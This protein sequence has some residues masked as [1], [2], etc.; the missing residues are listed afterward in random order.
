MNKHFTDKVEKYLSV[1]I[2]EQEDFWQLQLSE[3]RIDEGLEDGGE[4]RWQSLIHRDG[5]DREESSTDRPLRDK[6]S[7]WHL[8]P[9][10]MD[11]VVSA[12]RP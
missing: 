5:G 3:L 6:A 12:S 9:G 11:G 1:K 4:K 2:F 7:S 10:R 8:A